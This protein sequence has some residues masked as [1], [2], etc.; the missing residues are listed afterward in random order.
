MTRTGLTIRRHPALRAACRVKPLA[1]VVLVGC[2]GRAQLA[3][4]SPETCRWPRQERR[5]SAA[6][7]VAPARSRA[8][9]RLRGHRAAGARPGSG[10]SSSGKRAPAASCRFP[11]MV[12]R[13][14]PD[15]RVRRALLRRNALSGWGAWVRGDL[16][17]CVVRFVPDY[18]YDPPRA[19][20]LPGMPG[21][22]HG[23]SGLR[24]WA[25]GLHEA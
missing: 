13:L 18:R 1:E 6:R 7:A 21:V 4:R 12:Q 22:Y 3:R 16:D 8:P 10:N 15:S 5:W 9:R 25:A 11:G 24:R 14:P 2:V 23:H 17:L 20:L 19:W